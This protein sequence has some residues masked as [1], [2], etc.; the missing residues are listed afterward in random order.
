MPDEGDACVVVPDVNIFLNIA[1]H[2]GRPW[3]IGEFGEVAA[4][5]RKPSTQKSGIF[6]SVRCIDW[7]MTKLSPHS[8]RIAIS[9]AD[10]ILNTVFYKATQPL[11]SVEH[12]GQGLGWSKADAE[13]IIDFIQDIVKFTSGA[14]LGFVPPRGNPPLDHEDGSVL[15]A[16]R[17]AIQATSVANGYIVTC[18]NDFISAAPKSLDVSV[19]DPFQWVH[20]CRKAERIRL[21]QS[22]PAPTTPAT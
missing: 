7:C 15:G 20:E 10:H 14:N 3:D 19:V 12:N 17:A 4:P 13:K 9:T 8:L 1:R 16:A 5:L 22:M 2:V 6:D 18:D 21:I 11:H